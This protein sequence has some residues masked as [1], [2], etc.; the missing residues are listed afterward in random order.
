MYIVLLG[1]DQSESR[2]VA[3]MR[4]LGFCG[5]CMSERFVVRAGHVSMHPDATVDVG[6]GY[7]LRVPIRLRYGIC[8]ISF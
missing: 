7:S 2:Y 3:S 5:F 6:R 8:F 1:D 4:T